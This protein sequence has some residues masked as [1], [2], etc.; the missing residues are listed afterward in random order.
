MR[1][2]IYMQGEGSEEYV[3]VIGEVTLNSQY[4]KCDIFWWSQN[5]IPFVSIICGGNTHREECNYCKDFIPDV[6]LSKRIWFLREKKYTRVPHVVLY[7]S[8]VSFNCMCTS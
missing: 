5:L 6:G 2:H 3:E 1:Y 7:F 8:L 4:L